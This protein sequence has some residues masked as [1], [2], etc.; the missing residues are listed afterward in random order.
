[1]NKLKSYLEFSTKD[2]HSCII[3]VVLRNMTKLYATVKTNVNGKI[4]SHSGKITVEIS[5]ILYCN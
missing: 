3:A 2:H 5:E 1:M 4:A